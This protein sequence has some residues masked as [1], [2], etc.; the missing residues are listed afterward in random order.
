M[1]TGCIFIQTCSPGTS[2]VSMLESAVPGGGGGGGGGLGV[3]ILVI[4]ITTQTT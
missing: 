1:E 4:K 2:A 3:V